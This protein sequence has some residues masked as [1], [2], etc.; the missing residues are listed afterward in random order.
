MDELS[1]VIHFK[2]EGLFGK[3]IKSVDVGDND[4]PMIL[5]FM[6][7]T[8]ARCTTVSKNEIDGITHLTVAFDEVFDFEGFASISD[9]KPFKE[10]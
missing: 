10:G 3:N 4:L 5:E 6:D 1:I 7:G 9:D 2:T 8:K